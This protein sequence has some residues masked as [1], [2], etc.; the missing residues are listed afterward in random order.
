M[1]NIRTFHA[2]AI[3]ESHKAK[4]I[5][6]QDAAGSY[7]DKDNGIY[8]ATISDGH[9]NE[10]HF[11]SEY[12]SKILIDITLDTIKSFL[13]ED[14]CKILSVEYSA[15]EVLGGG[16]K[17]I[18]PQQLNG[19]KNE[20]Q[21]R[22]VVNLISSIISQWNVQIE[23][24]WKKYSPSKDTMVEKN[25]PE[26]AIDDYLKGVNLE[27]AYGCTLVAFARTKDFWLAFQIGDG[28][29]IA[30]LENAEVF[31]PIP[32]DERFT[33]SKTASMCNSDAL[34]NFRYA[35]G[36][37]NTP[38]AVFVGSDGMDGVFGTI[39]EFALPRLENLYANIVKMFTNNGYEN[40]LREI[41]KSLPELS[42]KGVTRDDMSIAGIIEFDKLK[43]SYP[44]FLRNDII[45]TKK[46]I[47]DTEKEYLEKISRTEEKQKEIN[48]KIIER[49]ELALKIEE[50]KDR[51]N[52]TETE[53]SR[54]KQSMEPTSKE[55]NEKVILLNEMESTI[56]KL[57]DNIKIAESS[58][59]KIKETKQTLEE[60]LNNLNSEL[61]KVSGR[62]EAS[63]NSRDIYNTKTE[64][65]A[66]PTSNTDFNE[67]ID[68]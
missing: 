42:A 68:N 2:V 1:N 40:T 18:A 48:N 59:D 66:E 58:I 67:N 25:V 23:K 22:I 56:S 49:E 64:D 3:G 14:S 19:R 61:A 12:G 32:A 20:D 43:T 29:C 7:E 47:E 27:Y 16:D 38:I 5:P 53:I 45:N 37:T 30:F 9:G 65:K 50:L 8:I 54:L 60:K 55:I 35:Y 11:M 46:E 31:Y 52:K 57:N 41:E 10:R 63:E 28:A 44:F 62:S 21:N 34:D 17:D 4:N 26:D 15:S 39:D 6:C 33:G 24:H 36:N 13:T 51:L